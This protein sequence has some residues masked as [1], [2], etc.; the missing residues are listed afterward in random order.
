MRNTTKKMNMRKALE[1]M[2]RG[3]VLASFDEKGLLVLYRVDEWG[4][5][6]HKDCDGWKNC[7]RIPDWSKM[8]EYTM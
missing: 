4:T 5:L 8:M 3:R 7:K 6:E 2:L 1:L